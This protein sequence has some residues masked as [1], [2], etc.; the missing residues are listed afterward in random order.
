M[1]TV[2]GGRKPVLAYAV[3]GPGRR[4]RGR[5]ERLV[6]ESRVAPVVARAQ[7]RCRL[8]VCS[9]W[10]VMLGY[11]KVAAGPVILLVMRIKTRRLMLFF[12]TA[13]FFV[14]TWLVYSDPAGRAGP[15]L[16]E[17]AQE[18][19]ALWH[20]HNCQACHQLFGFGG[21]LG[22]DLTNVADRL[23]KAVDDTAD[24]N[25]L[26]GSR[27]ETVLTSG[28]DRMPAFHLAEG[29]RAALIAFFM[30]VNLT[31]VGQVAVGEDRPPRQVLAEVL[32]S[33]TA[34]T[35]IDAVQAAGMSLMSEKGCID[36]HLPNG[37]SPFRAPDLTTMHA[38]I[39]L[40][41]LSKSRH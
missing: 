33:L 23:G 4:I 10:G 3:R 28:S 31:G 35:P 15:P 40:P 13:V 37:R 8:R 22:P 19:S 2:A 14:Q 39:D 41:R 34:R 36:C 21:F 27:M 24:L 11:T 29:E 26:L 16:S 20:E 5:F 18:G 30:E 38:E 12:L 25:T 32:A 17:L 9:L 1:T 6:L 7:M